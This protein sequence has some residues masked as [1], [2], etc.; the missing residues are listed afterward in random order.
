ME[1]V[2]RHYSENDIEALIQFWNKN[3]DWDELNREKWECRFHLPSCK[4]AVIIAVDEETQE[5]IGQCMFMPFNVVINGSEVRAYRAYGAV[6]KKNLHNKFGI[7]CMMAGQHPVMK[8]Y[9]KAAEDFANEGAALIYALPDPRAA[10][11]LQS[12]PFSTSR[13]SL[14][15]HE[16]PL[17]DKF[18]LP[19]NIM[20]EDLSFSDRRIDRLWSSASKLYSCMTMRNHDVF[21]WKTSQE[22]YRFFGVFEGN[23]MTGFFSITYKKN[24]FQ[25]LIC[26][27][28]SEDLEENL[29]I[30]LQAACNIIQEDFQENLSDEE[31]SKKIALLATPPIESAIKKLGFT[32]DDYNFVLGV[33]LLNRNTYSLNDVDPEKW[34][35][36]AND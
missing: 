13:F 24:D 29:K 31:H 25:W 8:M 20:V 5:I 14:W 30:T 1:V 15:S 35:I 22:K 9:Y 6:L 7:T 36:S 16:L 28:L 26:D 10:K 32:V 19:E 23:K 3:S 17:L 2:Y 21:Q 11:I 4:A 12:M 33:H 27:L 34:F 18:R